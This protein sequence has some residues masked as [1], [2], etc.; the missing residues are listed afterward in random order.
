MADTKINWTFTLSIDGGPRLSLAP[1]PD[2]TVTAYDLVRVTVPAMTGTTPGTVTADVQPATAA[3]K[4]RGLV[5]DADKYDAKLAY[6][7]TIGGTPKKIVLDGPQLF[8]G[9]GMVAALADP[10]PQA[11]TFENGTAAA[12]G[13]RVLVARKA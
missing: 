11:L 10:F 13:V 12:V 1:P 2:A 3:G 7:L 9:G 4:V 5:I 8:L 6:T